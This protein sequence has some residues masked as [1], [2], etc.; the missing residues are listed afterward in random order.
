M[1]LFY[2]LQIKYQNES[3]MYK[4]ELEL[5]EA[6]LP[7]FQIVEND[8]NEQ[9]EIWHFIWC[10]SSCLTYHRTVSWSMLPRVD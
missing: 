9:K 6:T 5:D 3:M 2:E 7:F 8:K 1:N 4:E 10:G